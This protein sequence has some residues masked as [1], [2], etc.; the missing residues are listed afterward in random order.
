MHF[1]WDGTIYCEQH[2]PTAALGVAPRTEAGPC[3]KCLT[4]IGTPDGFKPVT[5]AEK[6]A[7]SPLELALY[8]YFAQDS[9]DI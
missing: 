3:V 4:H 1:R 8:F 7:T 9:G 2:L 5:V 6:F